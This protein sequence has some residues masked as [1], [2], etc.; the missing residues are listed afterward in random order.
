MN[1]LSDLVV[2]VVD[3][4]CVVIREIIGRQVFLGDGG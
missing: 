4:G 3:F 1:A 2:L